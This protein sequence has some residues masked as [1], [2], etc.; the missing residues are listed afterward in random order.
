MLLFLLDVDDD[1][2]GG[3]EEGN[4][5]KGGPQSK[6]AVEGKHLLWTLSARVMAWQVDPV[7]GGIGLTK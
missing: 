4:G 6:K 7:G 5:R 1:D 3:G 2:F